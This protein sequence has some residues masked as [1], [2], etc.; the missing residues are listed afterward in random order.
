[1]QIFIDT[2]DLDEIREA[3]SWGIVDGV[4]T[5]PSL[6][7]KAV[8]RRPGLSMRDYIRDICRSVEGPVSLEVKGV[9][10]EQMVQEAE[11]LY[12]RFNPVNGNV[13]VKV[14]VSTAM[15]D[16]QPL[17]EGIR[18]IKTLEGRGIP[19]NATLVMTAEQALMAAKAGA[20]YASPFLGRV[21]DYLRTKLDIAFDK[22]DYYDPLCARHLEEQTWEEEASGAELYDRLMRSDISDNGIY[23]GVDL[24]DSIVT[25]YDAYGFDTQ[26]IAASVRNAR[27]AREV[28]EMGVDI[29][30][31]PFH[32]IEDMLTHPKTLEGM[33]LFTRD[34]V[35]EYEE[36]FE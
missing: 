3:Y 16:G 29:A 20:T 24:V 22:S 14:P 35:P 34:V 32:V 8:D 30:T 6:I 27:Q 26:V 7:K 36:L 9:S 25:I 31:L 5:N 19:T 15:E 18:A 4:T 17:F 21:D 28:A 12:E 2:A 1:M 10:T 23:S 11:M 13:V 33:Q